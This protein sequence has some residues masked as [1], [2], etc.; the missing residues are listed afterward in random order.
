MKTKKN[1]RDQCVQWLLKRAGHD[2]GCRLP[3]W[4]VI[5]RCCLRPSMV[6]VYMAAKVY[7]PWND[8]FSIEGVK[9]SR[10]WFYALKKGPHP[11]RWFRAVKYEEKNETV[12]LETYIGEHPKT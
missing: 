4:A 6:L 8:C 1:K 5:L 12:I 9:I 11:S 2:A 10:E 3:V 7:D